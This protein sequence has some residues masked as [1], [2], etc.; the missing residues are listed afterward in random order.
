MV[1]QPPIPRSAP[2]A[3]RGASPR[4]LV[5]AAALV[6][7]AVG[8]AV[9]VAV[10]AGG[11]SSSSTLPAIGRI[12]GGVPGAADVQRLFQ[13]I[14]Q[15]GAVLGSSAAPV[16]MVE[17]LDLQ[18]PY[19][20]EF[21]TVV[22]PKLLSRY[23]RTGKLRI[24]QRMLAFLGPDSVSGRSAALAA[25]QQARQFNFSEL[26]YFNQGVENTGWLDQAVIGS[27]AASIP[28]V[29]V[30]KLLD[31]A[32]SAAVAARAAAVD[33]EARVAGVSG[34]PTILVGKTGTPPTAVSLAS[35]TDA[36]SIVSAID[37]ALR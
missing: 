7:A 12:Q 5:G 10:V 34:T 26:L 2:R 35:P 15:H 20:R 4:V 14:P 13:G 16:T 6:I 18:C 1:T 29:R 21:E 24:E 25:G 17:Y 23:V 30:Q 36:G 8:I 37:A 11:K 9:V 32:G 19:C 3:P 31:D 27:A 22:M 28:G 33:S